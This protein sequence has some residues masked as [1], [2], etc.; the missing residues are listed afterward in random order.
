MG[1]NDGQLRAWKII[2]WVGLALAIVIVAGPQI[3]DL[4]SRP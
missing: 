4:L 2:G 1:K 3:L